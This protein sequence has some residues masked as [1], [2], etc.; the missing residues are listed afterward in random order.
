VSWGLVLAGG[1]VTGLAWEAGVIVGL[2]DAGVDLTSA[3]VVVGTSAGSIVG[4]LVLGGIAPSELAG[5]VADPERSP[6]EL[7]GKPK[8]DGDGGVNAQ[9]FIRWMSVKEFDESSTS[10]IAQLSL[11]S[12]TMTE[13][14][15]VEA[16]TEELGE[17]TWA[18]SLRIVSVDVETGRRKLWSAADSAP[19]PSVVA[20]SCAV[21]GVFPAVE[22]DGTKYVDGG[23]W[24][25]TSADLLLDAGLDAVVVVSPLGGSD[26]MGVAFNRSTDREVAELIERGIDTEVLRP[27]TPISP[28]SAFDDSQRIPAFEA[29]IVDG[30]AAA[31]RLGRVVGVA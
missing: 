7:N 23:L 1:G 6:L 25:P 13:A 12:R 19:L 18:P 17:R 24:S 28:L 21:P 31:E 29:G 2:A 4:S 26:P 22:I 8:N 15:W 9:V 16:F 11:G 30:K 27:Q 14:A 10:A 5:L 20:S 3:D